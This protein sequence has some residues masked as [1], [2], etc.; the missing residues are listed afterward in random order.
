[1]KYLPACHK[2]PD[3]HYCSGLKWNTKVTMD[4]IDKAIDDAFQKLGHQARTER[5]CT[6]CVVRA[7]LF[8]DCSY[9]VWE[10]SYFQSLPLCAS[11]ILEQF[12]DSSDCRCLLVP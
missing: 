4:D 11:M 10:V 8:C 9:W 1:M 6:M 12:S 3:E 2:L 5:G 7:G